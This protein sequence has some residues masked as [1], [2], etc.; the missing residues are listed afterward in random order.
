MKTGHNWPKSEEHL[1][2][3]WMSKDKIH[4]YRTCIHPDC[5]HT[6]EKEVK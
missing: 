3:P 4:V 5:K 6:E 2:G 1:F